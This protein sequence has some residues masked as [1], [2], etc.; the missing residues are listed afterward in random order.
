MGL[1]NVPQT[2]KKSLSSLANV[3]VML[4]VLRFLIV[5]ASHHEFLPRQLVNKDFNLK[6]MK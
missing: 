5:R 4:S 6:V 2:Q 3:N 1:K